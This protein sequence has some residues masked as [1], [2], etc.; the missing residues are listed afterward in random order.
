V[1]QSLLGLEDHRKL[2]GCV[3]LAVAADPVIAAQPMVGQQAL[4]GVYRVLAS[5]FL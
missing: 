1:N 2:G 4:E 5:T 3:V